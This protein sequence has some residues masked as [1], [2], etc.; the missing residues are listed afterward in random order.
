MRIVELNRE[1]PREGRAW[2][3]ADFEQLQH[4]LQRARDEEVLLRKPQTFADLGLVVR[5]QHLREILRNDFV[6]D[7]RVVVARVEGLE[8]ERLDGFGAPEPQR[9]AR[10]DP[11]ARY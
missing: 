8:V 9:V 11:I 2:L 1:S 3:A 6:L 5:V 7:G 4:V 10:V